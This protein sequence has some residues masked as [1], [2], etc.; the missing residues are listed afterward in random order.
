MK[1][2][3]E[4]FWP[5]VAML[6]VTTCGFFDLYLLRVGIIL[7]YTKLNQDFICIFDLGKLPVLLFH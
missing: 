6:G 2:I 4:P 1:E 3:V 7:R 5:Y